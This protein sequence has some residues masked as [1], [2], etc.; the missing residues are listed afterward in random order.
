[1]Q[2]DLETGETIEMNLEYS[3]DLHEYHKHLPFATEGRMELETTLKINK[4]M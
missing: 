4:N 2:N 1:M 3:K